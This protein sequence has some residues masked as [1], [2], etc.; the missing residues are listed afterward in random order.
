[1]RTQL[2]PRRELADTRGTT[3]FGEHGTVPG[4]VPERAPS[5][6]ECLTAF[7]GLRRVRHWPHVT[8]ESKSHRMNP[9]GANSWVWVAP[10]R[11]AA[12]AEIAPRVK[13]MDFDLL[14][15]GVENPDEW[16][17]VRIAEILAANDLGA[18]VC[19]VMGEGRD[20]LQRDL[21]VSPRTTFA[22][23]SI[24]PSPS[25]PESWLVPSMPRPARRGGS[26]TWNGWR[27]STDW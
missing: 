16:D 1:M 24:R 12:I 21:I 14:E 25:D 23:V 26:T 8:M 10:P 5:F 7:H 4:L 6:H 11:D 3:Y 2:R 20:L 19:A 27:P 15:M 17:P 9:M 18:S 22:P 13:E